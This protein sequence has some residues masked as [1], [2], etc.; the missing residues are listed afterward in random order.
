MCGITGYAGWQRD[1]ERST[2]E[3]RAMC[4]AIIHRGPDEEGHHVAPDVAL[5]MRR[6][7]VIDPAG[8]SQPMS[9]ETDTVHV[10]FN[11]E[12]YNFRRL[13]EQLRHDHD[14]RTNSDTEVLVHLYEEYGCGM[15]D[16]L[17]GMFAFAIWDDRQHRLFLSRDRLGIKPLYYWETASFAPSSRSRIFRARWMVTRCA[18]T[19]PWAT[20]PIRPASSRECESCRPATPSPGI[21]SAASR[22]DGTGRRDD[23]N[24]RWPMNAPRSKSCDA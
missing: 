18:S 21:G 7:R 9:N 12:I 1:A 13:R 10:V 16:H 24:S 11:G 17:R 20:Y 5:G 2:A 19:S 4:G 15:V 22:C 8:G 6:L 3:L 23:P 14:L